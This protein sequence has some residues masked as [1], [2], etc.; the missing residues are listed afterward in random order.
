MGRRSPVRWSQSLVALLVHAACAVVCS[1]LCAQGTAPPIGSGSAAPA[2]ES[3]DEPPASVQAEYRD[4]V[5]RAI[6]E[7]GAGRWAE[8]RSL[9]LRAHTLWPSARTW[10]SLGMTSFELRKY[11]RALS[12]LQSAL[13]DPRRPLSADQRS[14]VQ[15]LIEQTRSFV[16]RYRLRLSPSDAQVFVDGT[17]RAPAPGEPL[18]LGVGRHELLIRAPGH[19]DV[20]RAIDVQGDEDDELAIV[21][22][23]IGAASAVPPPASRAT[24]RTQDGDHLWTWV[25]GGTALAFGAASAALWFKSKAEF[26]ELAQLCKEQQCTRGELDTSSVELPETA[27]RVTLGLAIGA[28]AS[29]IALFFLEGRSQ[30]SEPPRLAFGPGGLRVQASF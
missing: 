19:V 23:P 24:A 3:P 8:A 16:G 10:R 7:F 18:L 22:R 13:D 9:F 5:E 20:R 27:H 29:A 30:R 2:I 4:V 25:A 15:A 12:E 14:Q 1:G 21:L 26:D 28:G 6:A 11:G 17:P